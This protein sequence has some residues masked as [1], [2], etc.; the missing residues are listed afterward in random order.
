LVVL[1]ALGGQAFS[2]TVAVGNCTSLPN[3]AT[4]QQAIDG[5]PAGSTIKICPA[6][7]REQVVITQQVKLMGI[8]YATQDAI[9]ILPPAGGMVGNAVSVDSGNP[10]AAQILVKDTTGPVAISNLT[11]DGT[12]NNISGCEPNLMGVLFQNA[13]GS[14]THVAVRNEVLGAG[15]GGCQ[16]GQGIFVQTAAGL[17]STV[18][19]V[20]SS[21]HAYNKNGITGNDVGTTLTVTGNYVQGAGVVPVPGAAQNGIQLGFGA[22]GK[23]SGNTVID[24]IYG[25]PTVAAS[26][27]ILLYDTAANSGISVATNT[28]GG[29]QLPIALFT[30]VTDGS[31]DGVIV[32]SNKIFGTATYD[33]IDVCTNSNTIKSNTIFNS[34]TSGVHLDASCG[35]SGNNNT[36]TGNTILESACAGI[37]A[38]TGTSGN[39]VAS[40]A[41]YTVPFT[42]KSSTSGCTIPNQGKQRLAKI[43]RTVSPQR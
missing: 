10:I 27:D 26:A 34:A 12:G 21:V 16:S 14:L 2:A 33:A 9:V 40:T 3:Y 25:D 23:V 6:T 28:L 7:Y 38:D 13:S 42:T 18:S 20:N 36:V 43:G 17:T 15:L 29:S 41:Y 24:N 31:G 30:D 1:S 39:T 8:V 22:A 4:I 19:I 5:V 35:S 37:L 32:M 11:V